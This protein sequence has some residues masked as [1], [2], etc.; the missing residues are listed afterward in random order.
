MK[1]KIF[2]IIY[3][4]LILITLKLMY[5]SFLNTILISK[6]HNGEYSE[7]IAEQ[8]TLFNFPQSYVANYNYGNILYQNGEYESAIEQ[9]EK[10]L[11][12]KSIPEQKE[13]CVRI[14]YSLAIC[15][16][17]KLDESNAESI[18]KAISTYESAIDVLTE[19]GCANKYDDN[20]HSEKAEKLKKD[21]Q[22]EIER[23][24]KLL[25]ENDENQDNNDDK[26]EEDK[27]QQKEEDKKTEEIETKIQNIKEE[28][29]KEQRESE[30]KYDAL[31]KEFKILKG[32]NW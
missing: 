16:T 19:N 13:C 18:K 32:K 2:I 24:K 26:N 15:K 14:N 12:D 22:K 6:Y 30:G 8:L 9:Y 10:A 11:N 1:K 3:I 17:V 5:N 20:G 27:E 23:L 7:K 4:I 21:I 28:A 25:E 31:I 29:T